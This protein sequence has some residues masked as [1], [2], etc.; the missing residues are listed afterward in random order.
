MNVVQVRVWPRK[1]GDPE[2]IDA[3]RG[4]VIRYWPYEEVEIK[5]YDSETVHEAAWRGVDELTEKHGWKR[6]I[7]CAIKRHEL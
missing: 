7:L 4:F 3:I 5:R 6:G 1:E 2:S